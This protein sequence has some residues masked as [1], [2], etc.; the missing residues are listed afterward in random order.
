[1]KKVKMDQK[2]HERQLQKGFLPTTAQHEES[3]SLGLLLVP[4]IGLGL[5]SSLTGIISIYSIRN[6]N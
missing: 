6:T 5:L 2:Y 4:N 1:M 3:E